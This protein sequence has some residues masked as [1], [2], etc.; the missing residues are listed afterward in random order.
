MRGSRLTTLSTRVDARVSLHAAHEVGQLLNVVGSSGLEPSVV[1]KTSSTGESSPSPQCAA[2]GRSR[3]ATGRPSAGSTRPARR[4]S[5]RRNGSPSPIS[6]A[7]SGT[8]TA[9]G[10]AITDV[11]PAASRSRDVPC[12]ARAA[13][14]ASGPIASASMRGPSTPSSAG[15]SVSAA[16]TLIATTSAPAMPIDRSAVMSK[17][18]SASKP[19][20]TVAPENSTARPAVATDHATAR[21]TDSPARQLFAEA[22]DD[23]Q[24]VVDAQAQAE[25]GGQIQ[26]EDRQLER[27][28]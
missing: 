22:A 10:R 4:D 18:S 9:T 3:G 24:R 20:I 12:R 1:W 14:A 17:V 23:E 28:G 8:S 27:P 25:H 26:R 2:A 5:T 6:S 19:I 13:D 16:R 15:S 7:S 11:A 21:S